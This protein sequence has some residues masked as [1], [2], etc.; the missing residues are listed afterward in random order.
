MLPSGCGSP[1][2]RMQGEHDSREQSMGAVVGRLLAVAVGHLD[3]P[4]LSLVDVAA[5]LAA[6]QSVAGVLH[7]DGG[8]EHHAVDL[9]LSADQRATRVAWTYLRPD[10]VNAAHHLRVAVDV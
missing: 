2:R 3:G 7:R 4:V 9:A 6:G 8:R 1:G 5:E 10:R